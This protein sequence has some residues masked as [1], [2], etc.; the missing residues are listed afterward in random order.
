MEYSGNGLLDKSMKREYS[1]AKLF[2]PRSEK[3]VE[4]FNDVDGEESGVFAGGGGEDMQLPR[5]QHLNKK[6]LS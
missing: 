1:K 4:A 2:T 6:G 3:N 5:F